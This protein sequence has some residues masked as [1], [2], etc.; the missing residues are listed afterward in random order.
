VD[1]TAVLQSE[2]NA[3]LQAAKPQSV[4][5]FLD[6]CYSGLAK[7]GET[8]VASARPVV[9]TSAQNA[10]PAEFTVISA[11]QQDQISSSNEELKHGIFSYF[12]MRGMEGDADENR[13]G[14]ITVGEMHGYLKDQVMRQAGAVNRIQIPQL[15]GDP[16][17]VLVYR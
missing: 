8:L 6:S 17:R 7:T 1:K 5:L 3:A 4:T 13:D 14:R 16:Q 12:L 2:I 11:A 9:L 10:F 15:A